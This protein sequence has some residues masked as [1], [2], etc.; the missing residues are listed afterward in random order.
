MARLVR[1]SGCGKDGE[2]KSSWEDEGGAST[3]DTWSRD[4]HTKE[5][6]HDKKEREPEQK[7]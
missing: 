6:A 5:A 1:G 4:N 2:L 3:V 7:K